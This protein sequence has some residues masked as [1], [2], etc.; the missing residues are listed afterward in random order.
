MADWTSALRTLAA[1][2]V[3]LLALVVLALMLLLT[4]LGQWIFAHDPMAM[5]VSQRLRAPNWSHWSGTDELGRDIT[6]RIFYG[7]RYSLAIGAATAL[8]AVVFGSLLGLLAGFFSRLDAA[9]MRCVD[10]MM[11]FPDILLGIA[12]VSI[13]GASPVNVVLAL[14]IV[15]TPRVARVV[16]AS[17]LV[18][19]ELPYVEA[20]RAVGVSTPRPLAVHILPNL[21]SPIL[22]QLSFIFAYALLAEA[23]LS[24]LGVGVGAEI[25]TWGTMVA[26]SA[27]YADRAVWTL[28]FPGMALV[29]TALSLQVLGDG[30]RDLLDPR[31]KGAT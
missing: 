9:L 15:Y 3:V 1:R 10:A 30:V 19:R 17:T 2:R 20:A 23:G 31:L 13:L 5:K 28:F 16:R 4:A 25:P 18:I 7:A 29:L 22:V 6:S 26:A 27:Q 12:L 24:F 11:A 14:T 21:M 8:L